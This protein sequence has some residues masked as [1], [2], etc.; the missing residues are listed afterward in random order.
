MLSYW[1]YCWSFVVR[2]IGL[3]QSDRIQPIA[4]HFTSGSVIASKIKP[5]YEREKGGGAGEL[6]LPI[7]L[8]PTHPLIKKKDVHF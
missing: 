7:T 5:W 6:T 8:H 2:Q 4:H 1:R 3:Q